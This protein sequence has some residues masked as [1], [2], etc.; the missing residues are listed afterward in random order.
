MKHKPLIL[1]LKDCDCQFCLYYGGLQEGEVVC[2]TSDCPCRE[3]L[4]EIFQRERA[5]DG[6]KNQ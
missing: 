2:L 5:H 1:T 3:I 4:Q 6:R